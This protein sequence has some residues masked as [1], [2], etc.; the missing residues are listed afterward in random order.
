MSST[1]SATDQV[2]LRPSPHH[3]HFADQRAQTSLSSSGIPSDISGARYA[4]E[5]EEALIG[6]NDE[7]DEDDLPTPRP[8]I[9]RRDSFSSD[10]QW[11]TETEARYIPGPPFKSKQPKPVGRVG[12]RAPEANERTPLLRKAA[13]LH[14]D[15]RP[16]RSPA[17]EDKPADETRLDA[18]P[19]LAHR[20]SMLS[21]HAPQPPVHHGKSTFGQTVSSS[22]SV[23]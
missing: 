5:D 13:S 20:T 14:I 11:D 7:Y 3:H 15:T 21:V 6:T 23:Q 1:S 9:S 16:I 2:L 8:N 17:D 12:V 4:D 18:A 22:L 10:S 19:S